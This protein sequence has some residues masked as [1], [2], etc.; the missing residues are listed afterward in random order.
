MKEYPF[1]ATVKPTRTGS[2]FV[3]IPAYFF[4]EG[5]LE[6]GKAAKFLLITGDDHNAR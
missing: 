2:R 1:T 6:E 3:L 4:N 5:I